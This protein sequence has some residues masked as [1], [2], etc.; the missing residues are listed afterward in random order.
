MYTDVVNPLTGIN[1][2]SH[3]YGP[4]KGADHETVL[5]LDRGLEHLNNI[6]K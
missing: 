1:G 3:I 2:A 4:Q 6:F 5:Q